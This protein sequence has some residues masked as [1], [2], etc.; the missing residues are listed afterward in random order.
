MF[1]P[2]AKKLGT[3]RFPE[4]PANATFGGKDRKTLYVT[5]RTSVYSVPMAAAGH[6]CPRK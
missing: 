4:Q 5:A 1:D 2:A 6:H 3:I